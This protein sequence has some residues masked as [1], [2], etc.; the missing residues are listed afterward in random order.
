[1]FIKEYI[2]DDI[3]TLDKDRSFLFSM[4]LMDELK[5]SCLPVVEGGVYKGLLPEDIV[6]ELDLFSQSIRECEHLLKPISLTDDK[7][8]FDAL[9]IFVQEK[10]DLIPVIDN[11]ERYLGVISQSGLLKAL[12]N[13]TASEYEGRTLIL[14]M[15]YNDLHISEIAKIIEDEDANIINLFVQPLPQ[16]TEI[17]V[18]IKINK[19]DLSRIEKSLQRHNYKIAFLLQNEEED[20]SLA[21]KYD[22]FMKY[23]NL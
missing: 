22:L 9:N 6:Y 16:S 14:T 2:S 7:T 23:L 19:I 20:E 13:L 21:L 8:I 12:S 3:P 11:N 15:N 10:T 17:N 18:I 5:I 4:T 1:M